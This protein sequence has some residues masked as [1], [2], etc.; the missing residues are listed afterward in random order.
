MSMLTGWEAAYREILQI[1]GAGRRGYLA[2]ASSQCIAWL[3]HHLT[4]IL[5]SPVGA[6]FG[7]E[8]QEWHRN[9][10]HRAKAG[11]RRLTKPLRCPGCQMLLLVW[12]EGTDRV[13]CGNPACARVW[14]YAEYEAM[15]EERSGQK[16]AR[17]DGAALARLVCLR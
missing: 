10:R 16:L 17:E 9:W 11:R 2:S 14:T 3:G 12:E 15:V 6:D 4:G 1:P 8:V 13:C 5:G 7:V